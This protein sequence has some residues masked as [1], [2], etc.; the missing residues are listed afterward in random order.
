MIDW[1]VAIL[2]VMNMNLKM[3]LELKANTHIRYRM[4]AGECPGSL[5]VRHRGRWTHTSPLT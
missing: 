5:V 2:D 1:A 3:E 4:K